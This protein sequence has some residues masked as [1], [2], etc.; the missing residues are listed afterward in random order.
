[1]KILLLAILA[2][3]FL[4]ILWGPAFLVARRFRRSGD[5]AAF[6]WLRFIWPAQLIATLALVVLA[7]AAG[8]GNPAGLLVAATLLVSIAGAA[9]F[10]V[11]R[12]AFGFRSR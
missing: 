8:L 11:L 6:R 1:L 4:F 7:D 2:A 5:A 3:A 10:A 9:A 12:F